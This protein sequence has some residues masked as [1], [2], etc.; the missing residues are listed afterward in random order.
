MAE[1]TTH[2]GLDVHKQSISVAMLLP[3][4]AKATQWEI[5]NQPAQVRRLVSRL[6]RDAGRGA[7][8]CAYEAGPCG[9][10]LQRQLVRN[11][12]ACQVVAAS[13]IPR[14]PGERIKTDWRDARKLAELLRA[15]LLTEVRPPS[16]A[17]EALRDLC[18]CRDDARADLMRARHRLSKMLL[19][20]DLRYVEGRPWTQQHRSWLWS[21]KLVH[22]AERM[23]LEDYLLAVDQ[24][25]TRLATLD[26]QLKELADQEPYR[27]RIGWLRCFR[28]ID[29]ITALILLA[30]LHGFERFKK[31]RDLMS[32]VGLVPSEH[33]SG[34][35]VRRGGITKTGNRH[36]RRLLTEAAHHCRHRPGVG[37]ALRQR[38]AGQPAAVV[39]LADRAQQRL[40]R[41]YT[42]LLLGR[43]LPVQKIVVACARELTGFLW[44]LLYLHPHQ[45]LAAA[46]ETSA[47]D[48]RPRRPAPSSTPRARRNAPG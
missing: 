3:G 21:L 28:G 15:G 24:V 39:A 33:S 47:A 4:S 36:L 7:V 38:R 17:E 19:R 16:E 31:P 1:A 32:F 6:R 5:P 12:I 37:G 46:G 29:T 14:K 48:L 11:G 2:V 40:H 20:R 8:V 25:S 27:E 43:G 44:A 45:L 10:V 26:A 13:L 35:S 34:G 23:A 9:Y 41:R 42:R 22:A 18:R 30:E